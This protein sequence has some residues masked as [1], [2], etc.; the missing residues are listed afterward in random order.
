M[1][2][3]CFR[4]KRTFDHDQSVSQ[5]QSRATASTHVARNHAHELLTIKTEVHKWTARIPACILRQVGMGYPRTQNHLP[6][7]STEMWWYNGACKVIG[8]YATD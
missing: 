4:Y 3:I 1:F 6:Q 2:A 7:L 5:Y 8:H